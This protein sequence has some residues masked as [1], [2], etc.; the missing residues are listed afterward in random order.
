[1]RVTVVCTLSP[2][3]KKG[4]PK[5]ALTPS[6]SPVSLRHRRVFIVRGAQ[7]HRP[8]PSSNLYLTPGEAVLDVKGHGEYS[9]AL[10]LRVEGAAPVAP[11]GVDR[12]SGV[13]NIL[14]GTDPARWQRQ[15]PTY[16]KVIYLYP[17]IRPGVDWVFYGAGNHLEYD[18][19]VHPPPS[20]GPPTWAGPSTPAHQARRSLPKTAASGWPPTLSAT[21]MSPGAPSRRTSPPSLRVVLPG[22]AHQRAS[23]SMGD[24]QVQATAGSAGQGMG[25]ARCGA[26]APPGPV[27]PLAYAPAHQQPTVGAG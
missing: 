2:G 7:H 4:N 13:T 15:V 25:V 14:R 26:T 9:A 3:A 11:E 16:A 17:K 10:H 22:N 18:L 21:S 5:A 23:R 6:P 20:C 8:P 27:R 19:V 1:M 12:L 24:A